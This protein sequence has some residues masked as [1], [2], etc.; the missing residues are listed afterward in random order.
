MA[1]LPSPGLFW[2][3]AGNKT[4]RTL[5]SLNWDHQALPMILWR[6]RWLIVYSTAAAFLLAVSFLLIASPQFTATGLLQI[7]TRHEKI[8]GF[9]DV[10]SGLNADDAAVESEADVIR[11][12]KLARKV[13]MQLNLAD[14]PE[15]INHGPWHG[16]KSAALYFIAPGKAAP[17]TAE[18]RL[19]E[20]VDG[21][22]KRLEV[23]ILPR[24]YSIS[25]SFSSH[26]PQRAAKVV[27]ALALAY[28][29]NQLD[30]KFEATR[31]ANTWMVEHLRQLQ[32]DVREA[33]LAV[34]KFRESHGL[35]KAKGM[36]L[37]EQQLS[38]LNS[39]LILARSQ[40]AAAEAKLGRAKEM[41]AAGQGIETTS[42]VLDSPLI[43]NL[44]QQEAEVRRQVS[45][46][47]TRYGSRHPRMQTA[48][49]E[50][51][52]IQRKIR[53]ESSQIQSSLENDAVVAQARVQALQHQLDNLETQTRL[54]SEAEV[55]L[56]ELE[57][58]AHAE[59]TLY[60]DFLTRS[61]QISQM[62]FPQ[63]DARI[64]SNAD[65]PLKASHPKILLW[66]MLAGALGCLSGTLLAFLLERFDGVFRTG[67][68]LE[69]ET[70][71][72]LLGM[73]YE[74]AE[75]AEPETQVLHKPQGNFSEE[76]RTILTTLKLSQTARPI[77]VILVASATAGEGKT[78]CA[79]SLALSAARA[80]QKVLLVEGNFRQP[81]LAAR[82]HR[83]A[84][85]S[86]ADVLSKKVRWQKVLI[87]PRDGNLMLLPAPAMPEQAQALLSGKVMK[88]LV[89]EWRRKFDLIVIDSP[90]LMPVADALIL[91]TFADSVI[92]VVRG[93][94]T[95]K[96]TVATTLKRLR[97]CG[98]PLAG[99]IL[100]RVDSICR[101]VYRASAFPKHE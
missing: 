83:R 46:L 70:E 75:G 33:D 8:V 19:T 72:S 1:V 2:Q 38:E 4:F 34:D 97:A 49:N 22:L 86:L 12:R 47:A 69:K 87:Q 23:T 43:Q 63:P 3:Q 36:T 56:A 94:V 60:Q 77:Q 74:I 53:E 32:V 25:I 78:L 65:V 80:G 96:S 50:L 73:L 42:E 79:L 98:A 58:Q 76:I 21:F 5:A 85:Y 41:R 13:I 6:H 14:T 84:H 66:L 64:I 89:A 20:A 59:S 55:R 26:N 52:D 90:A 67:E 93:G 9:E 91:T 51:A 62:D 29:N 17:S 28:L 10:L 37:T 95:L 57:R 35:T 39:Q 45:E 11:S 15:L 61:R 48:R 16:I 24:S 18:S 100:S 88:D 71:L 31:R 54:S 44:R 101:D 27:N 81:A 99:C 40:Q 68:Q 7:N 82:L 92:F 30:E